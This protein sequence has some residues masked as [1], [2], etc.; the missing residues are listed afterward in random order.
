M[1]VDVLRAFVRRN[2]LDNTIPLSS[3]PYCSFAHATIFVRHNSS[4]FT[5]LVTASSIVH[6]DSVKCITVTHREYV[7]Y[8][9]VR[10]NRKK[11]TKEP[12][13]NG[14]E[15]N[16]TMDHFGQKTSRG[17]SRRRVLVQL[18]NTFV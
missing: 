4:I 8:C 5:F 9:T 14:P 11:K 2:V 3:F 1:V 18:T 13:D 7:S 16:L 10:V 17:R 15:D 6:D 12:F